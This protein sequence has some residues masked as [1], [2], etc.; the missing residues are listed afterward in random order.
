LVE[1]NWKKRVSAHNVSQFEKPLQTHD[2]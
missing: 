1:V 2:M